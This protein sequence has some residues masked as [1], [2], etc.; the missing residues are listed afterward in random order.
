MAEVLEMTLSSLMFEMLEM[1][2]SVK[3]SAKYSSRGSEDMLARGSTIIRCLSMWTSCCARASAFKFLD[4]GPDSQAL[5]P[6]PLSS[7]TVLTL[8]ESESPLQFKQAARAGPACIL[9]VW[10]F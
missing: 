6:T 5:S 10:D 1:S 2:S 7:V 3:P 9:L 8:L 4:F